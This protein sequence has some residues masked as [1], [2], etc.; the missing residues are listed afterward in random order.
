MLS[1][2]TPGPTREDAGGFFA[3]QICQ[4]KQS[5]KSFKKQQQQKIN[6]NIENQ[7]VRNLDVKSYSSIT[8]LL[9]R[10]ALWHT[11]EFCSLP[12]I[13]FNL[14]DPDS[15]EI[16]IKGLAVI[17][18]RDIM[19]FFSIHSFIRY[20]LQPQMDSPLQRKGGWV[21]GTRQ[22]TYSQKPRRLLREQT[23]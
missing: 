11:L 1:L 16:T 17:Y 8:A 14:N 7:L 15:Q 21:R 10:L 4:I 5:S 18:A 19:L 23:L 12:L 13:L 9:E 20:L 3:V 6:K 2:T 22:G